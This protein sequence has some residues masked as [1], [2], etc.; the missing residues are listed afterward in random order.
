MIGSVFGLA[1]QSGSALTSFQI[2][3]DD[4]EITSYIESEMQRHRL[5]GVSVAITQGDDVR[6]LSGFGT[7]GDG[8]PVTE[9]T[10]FFIG[11][12]SKSFTALAVMQLVDEGLVDLDTPAQDYIPWFTTADPE[13]SSRIT[14]R[15]LL[16]QTSGLS[17]GSF[18]RPLITEETTLEE[19][20]RHL[21]EAQLTTSPGTTFHYFN[22]NYNVL[23][24][25]IEAVTGKSFPDYVV[26]NI[27]NPLDMT[28]SFVELEPAI[29]AGL[30]NGH[31]YFFGF[32]IARQQPFNPADLAAGYMISTARDMA[33]YVIA[34][35]NEGLFNNFPVASPRA[36]SSMHTPPPSVET[37]YAMGWIATEVNG[38]STIRH[39]G[40]LEAFYSDVI[41][42][43]DYDIG[44]VLM[45]NQNALL[46]LTM[47]Y[48]P[49]ADGLV[50]VVLGNE[51]APGPSMRMVYAII[52]VIALLDLLRHGIILTR[53][54]VWFKNVE[55]K[56]P[57][58]QYLGIFLKHA[59]FPLVLAFLITLIYLNAGTN[60]TRAT[61]F[62]FIPDIALWLT[63]SALLSLVEGG[64]KIRKL[65]K[66]T[67]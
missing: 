25:V 51:P 55:R 26:E 29:D 53:I 58:R 18:R 43:P 27:F 61:L 5:K 33:N 60:A 56:N 38:I 31:N 22:P 48:I 32:P 30:A 9:D 28:H 67:A 42:L 35:N 65:I 45:I 37:D 2:P 50:N 13:I 8:N 34:Q 62:Y 39:N 11:S 64:I 47:T 21:N 59:L 4:A 15:Q 23:A 24:Q 41:L 12:V 52:S 36:V 17:D 54:P 44:V 40:S 20:I 19:T 7:D 10:P 16:N 49:L 3:I 63:I 46:P 66:N 6:Y 57:W 14:I 1:V